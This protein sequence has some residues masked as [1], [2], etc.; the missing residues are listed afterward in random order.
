SGLTI[1]SALAGCVIGGASAGAL[2]DRFG[3]KRGLIV[4]AV[5]F[6][7]SALGSAAPETGLARFGDTGPA[8]LVAFNLYRVLCGIGVGIASMLSPLYI[9]EIAP[10][11]RRGQLVS[12]NQMAIVTGIVGVYFVNWAIAQSGDEA[13][14]D[15]IGWRLMLASEALPALAFLLLLIPVPDT[16]RWLVLRGRDQEA[17]AVL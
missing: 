1:S 9:A 3:R 7:V 14:V 4:A 2:A 13:W 15:A 5:L 17:L 11:D 16:P 10:K 12:L 6:L 8:A